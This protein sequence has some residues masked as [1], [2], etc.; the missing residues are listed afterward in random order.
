M[1]DT[2]PNKID[3]DI[4]EQ[5]S[6]G[7]D[8]GPVLMINLNKY[9]S[10]SGFPNGKPYKEYMQALNILLKQVGGKILWQTPV[11]GQPIGN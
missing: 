5:I 6:K 10:N 2:H 7:D 4:I 3:Y 11:F 1:S 9:N 8:D